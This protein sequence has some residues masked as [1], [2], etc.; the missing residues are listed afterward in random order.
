MPYDFFMA[1]EQPGTGKVFSSIEN[2]YEYGYPPQKKTQSN[3]DALPVGFVKDEYL[4]KEFIGFSC[5]ACHTGQ[6]NYKGVGIRID[7]GPPAAIWIRFSR[8]WPRPCARHKRRQC[9]RPVREA[10]ADRGN[11]SSAKDVEDD[12]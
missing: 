1:L 4:G 7:G 2:L 10:S 5:A 9:S 8:I 3:P 11:Y 6:V 12:L